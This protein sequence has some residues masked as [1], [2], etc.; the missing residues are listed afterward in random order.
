MSG[1]VLSVQESMIE[2][3]IIRKIERRV[4]SNIEVP[5]LDS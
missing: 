4:P 1:Q 2:S 5:S 3:Y